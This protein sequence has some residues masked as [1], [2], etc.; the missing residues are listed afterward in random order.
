MT[1]DPDFDRLLGEWRAGSATALGELL[2]RYAGAV[3]AAVRHRL[4]DRLR[5]EYDSLDF[6]Q[7]VWSSV[8]GLS[9]DE[10]SFPTQAA[11]VGFLV[12]IAENKVVDVCRRRLRSLA[13]ARTRERPITRPD[14]ADVP[15]LDPGPTPS[16]WVMAAE[17]WAEIVAELPP[18][19][20]AV[21]ER[22]RAGYTRVE[23]AA[24]TGVT[25]RTVRRIVTRAERAMGGRP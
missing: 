24:M 19:H 6:V 18:L 10:F 22:L 4:N 15:V 23:V 12:R 9:P 2:D 16:Q 25:D 11:L 13:Y 21:L 1:P 17:R 7:D 5:A 3:R 8:V 20:V 14:G